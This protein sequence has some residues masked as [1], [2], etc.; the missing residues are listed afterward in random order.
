MKW[1]LNDLLQQHLSTGELCA[2]VADAKNSVKGLIGQM[3][4]NL[5][6]IFKDTTFEPIAHP[7]AKV[8]SQK[9]TDEDLL[10]EIVKVY[11]QCQ[12]M[13]EFERKA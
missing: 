8:A 5:T 12:V 9:E 4:D 2:G 7:S 13:I 6:K 3:G 11:T 10:D 1:L